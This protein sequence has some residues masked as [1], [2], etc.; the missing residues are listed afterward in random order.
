[1]AAKILMLVFV[2]MPPGR[3]IPFPMHGIVD[4]SDMEISQQD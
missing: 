3:W 1:M 4:Q 2:I